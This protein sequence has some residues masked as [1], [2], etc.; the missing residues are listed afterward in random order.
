M[1]FVFIE[2]KSV[3]PDFQMQKVRKY[4]ENT[5]MLHKKEDGKVSCQ[6]VNELLHHF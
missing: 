5:A 1:C 6:N 4:Q 3:P 2:K